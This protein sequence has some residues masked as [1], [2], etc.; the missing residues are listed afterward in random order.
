MTLK[1]NIILA[2]AL[3]TATLMQAKQVKVGTP[4]ALHAAI[5]NSQAG[6]SIIISN[7]TWK[8]VA[9]VLKGKG[10]K[11]KFISLIA[12][13]PGKV[14]LE[15]QSSL[16]MSGDW[17]Y[18]SGLVFRNG[19]S[20]RSNVIEF[21]TSSKDYAYN[22]VVS[23]CVIDNYNKLAKDSADHWVGI[24]GKNNRVEYSY[25]AGKTNDGTTLVVWPNDSNSIENNHLIYRN[26]FGHRPRLGSNGGE[27]IRI[28]T[29]HVC[30]NS[31][32]TIVDGNYFE[33][34]NG[35]TEIIS[36]K[37]TD[38]IFINN[39]F[40]ESEGSLVLR[41]GDNAIVAGN[42][43]IGNKKANT[44]GVRVINEG[45]KIY[46]NY[47]YKLTGDEFR[48][49]LAVMNGIPNSPLNGYM[50]VKNVIV[51]NNTYYDCGVVW[52]FGVGKGFRDRDVKPENVLLLNNIVYSPNQ[53]DLI[54]YYDP[55]PG[56]RFDNNIMKNSTGFFN[57]AGAVE[58]EIESGEFAGLKTI[59]SSLKAKKLP[60]VKY[61][62]LGQLRNE[63]VVG[64]FQ[65]KV[66][67]PEVEVATSKNCGPDWYRGSIASKATKEVKERKIIKVSNDAPDN[68]RKLLLKAKDGDIFELGEGE[69]VISNKIVLNKNIDIRGVSNAGKPVIKLQSTREN[70]SFF[71]IAE[72]AN[73]KFV[74][75]AFNGDSKSKFPAKYLFIT[76]KDGSKNYNLHIENCEIY[77]FNVETGAIFKAY[78][79]SFADSIVV[80][81]SVLRNSFRAFSLAEEKDNTGKYNAEYVIFENTV[82]DNFTQFVLDYYR[83]GMDESTIGGTLQ[84][85]HCVFNAIGA[86][87][88]QTIIRLSGILN[89][90]IENSIF[91]NSLA[92]TSFRLS[93]ERNVVTHCNFS[94]APEPKILNGAK[95]IK[96][97][98]ESPRFE[99]KS[100][101]LSSKSKLRNKG[102]NGLNIGLLD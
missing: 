8:D 34:C 77:D 100:F 20:P 38:N 86:D 1:F 98:Y 74:G 7:G 70:N 22:S 50:P 97:M 61:D 27:T 32:R 45:H 91:C 13:T 46:N 10:Q 26:Y 12:E 4:D 37:S 53:T 24:Y 89:V 72:T 54:K 55:S 88:K 76:A 57:N 67:K 40:F 30:M 33:H 42:W 73:V 11:D 51:A 71:E 87:E 14:F 16:R 19:F 79:G 36:N 41:H 43:F 93:G 68:L 96:L 17:L 102:L 18:V 25:F 92:K 78:K 65:N 29:S 2:M 101:K 84:V 39:T 52:A 80:R 48:S 60:F 95:A 6:D 49:P 85:K 75:I 56:I 47:F 3:L 59:F 21:R 90:S 82:F 9:I 62:I 35:E 66:V 44:G 64:A 94:A 28:G 69:Y 58:A 99:K 5:K 83:G 81:N 15:G 63:V 23:E 31:S